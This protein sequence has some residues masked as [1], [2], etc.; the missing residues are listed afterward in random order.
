MLIEFTRLRETAENE[1]ERPNAS[2][3]DALVDGTVLKWEHFKPFDDLTDEEIKKLYATEVKEREAICMEKNA[4]EVA[5]QVTALVDDDPGPAKGY[6][7]CYTSTT[8]QM[9]KQG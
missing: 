9:L 8:M 5:K 1:A 6:F 7:N 3:W 4:W 2:I